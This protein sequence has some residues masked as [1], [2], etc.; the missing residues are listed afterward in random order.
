[1]ES[2]APCKD[3]PKRHPLC[4]DQCE[5]YRR[6][7]EERAKEAAYTRQKKEDGVIHKRDFD[8]EFWM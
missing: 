6:W 4:H 1:M 5:A 8:K 7:K 3:C 2:R